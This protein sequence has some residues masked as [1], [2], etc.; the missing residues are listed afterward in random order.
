MDARARIHAL[1]P[2][3]DPATRAELDKQLTILEADTV[4]AVLS[5]VETHAG[6]HTAETIRDDH[7]PHLDPMLRGETPPP[8]PAFDAEA[9][10]A[11][12]RAEAARLCTCNHYRDK[13]ARDFVMDGKPI[14]CWSCDCMAFTDSTAA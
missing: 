3:L 14:R 9:F 4:Q 11:A 10:N 7:Y 2:D 5:N 12:A 8:A 1:L 6:D 13:H